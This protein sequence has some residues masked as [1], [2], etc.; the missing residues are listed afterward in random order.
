MARN[1]YVTLGVGADATPEQIK[2]AYRQHA[3]KFH[4][5]HYGQDSQPFRE[6]QEAYDVLVVLKR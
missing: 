1:Y 6:L 2:T 4:P 5:D 3:K